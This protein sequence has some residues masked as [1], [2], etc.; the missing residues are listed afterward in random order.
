MN[1]VDCRVP[2]VCEMRSRGTVM[3]RMARAKELKPEKTP[4]RMRSAS[5][6]QTLLTR[7]IA[8]RMKIQAMRQRRIKMRLPV[9]SAVRTQKGVR[10]PPSSGL[11]PTSKPGPERGAAGIVDAQPLDILRQEG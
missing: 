8:L 5:N 1:W 11:T 10:M 7:P 2:I 6:C 3:V 9:H 4:S